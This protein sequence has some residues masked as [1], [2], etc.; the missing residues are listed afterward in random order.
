[1]WN[2]Y[3]YELYEHC[4]ISCREDSWPENNDRLVNKDVSFVLS[5]F[6]LYDYL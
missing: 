4:N 2:E 5:V 3:G 1:M 6:E